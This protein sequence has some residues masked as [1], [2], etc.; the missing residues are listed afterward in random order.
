MT[1]A[2]QR[3][4]SVMANAL[5]WDNHACMPLRPGDTEHLNQ[6]AV[7]RDIGASVVSLNVGFDAIA[8][9]ETFKALATFRL[10]IK[11]RSDAYVLI[12][13][14]ADIAA[15]KASGRLG[16][17][18]DIEGGSA[19]D[20]RP[21]LIEAYYALGVRWML[22]AYNKNNALGGGCQDEDGGLTA[23]GKRVLDEM[24]RAGMVVCCSH[25][26]ARTARDV[27]DYVQGPVIFSHSNAKGV[28]DHP[29]NIS[30]DLIRACAA[31]GG[32]VGV[33]GFGLFTGDNDDRTET[34][35]RHIQYIADLVGPDH[36]GFG[37][38]Y[39]FDTDELNAYF[40]Q[41]PALFPP[42]KGYGAGVRMVE[43]GRIPA[44]IETLIKLG[45]RDAD[46]KNLLGGNHLRVA[47]A[48]WK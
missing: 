24:A 31:S 11:D 40:A 25:T 17:V 4:C 2:E 29:R 47:N 32:V 33:N 43:P 34:L 37:L 22:I 13:T 26:G 20:D 35:V 12:E 42:D 27:L 30:D 9:E 1:T 8:W 44:I 15:A 14:T 21:E 36:V 23:F 3:L 45:W 18:F 6:L 10:W 5:V 41:N 28:Y 39:V 46:L 19:V 16:V 38:D 48:V 7:Y